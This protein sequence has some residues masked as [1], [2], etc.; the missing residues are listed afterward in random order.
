MKSKCP[1][2]KRKCIQRRSARLCGDPTRAGETESRVSTTV[3]RS[4]LPVLGSVAVSPALCCARSRTC[5]LP[6]PLFLRIWEVPPNS[7]L[8]WWGSAG[9]REILTPL[10]PGRD[11]E[12]PGGAQTQHPE[13][14]PLPSSSWGGGDKR[15][16]WAGGCLLS[17]HHSATGLIYLFPTPFPLIWKKIYIG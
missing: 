10:T 7:A 11:V 3:P 6:S 13:S 8:Q 14:A 12:S 15:L 1:R 2:H 9:G 5:P 17:E 16:Q 4:V